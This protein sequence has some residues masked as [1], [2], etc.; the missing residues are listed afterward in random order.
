M[1]KCQTSFR[2]TVSLFPHFLWFQVNL[3]L[4][5]RVDESRIVTGF[6]PPLKDRL[7]S[8]GPCDCVTLSRLSPPGP[9]CFSSVDREEDDC[10]GESEV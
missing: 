8:L 9:A 10:T 7:S 3:R 1:V 4:L 5:L 6:L 2:M